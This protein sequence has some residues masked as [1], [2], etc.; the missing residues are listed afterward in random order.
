M[1]FEG[2]S[3]MELLAETEKAGSKKALHSNAARDADVDHVDFICK[4]LQ[5]EAKQ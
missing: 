3:R 5:L 2:L 1:L 4:A